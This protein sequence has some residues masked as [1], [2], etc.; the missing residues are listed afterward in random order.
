MYRQILASCEDVKQLCLVIPE[1]CAV[2]WV[3]IVSAYASTLEYLAIEVNC[4]AKILPIHLP[5]PK[6]RTLQ[7]RTESFPLLPIDFDH[8]FQVF[9]ATF[10]MLEF[11]TAY[12]ST[13]DWA[14]IFAS[15]KAYCPKLKEI[16]I[17]KNAPHLE[18]ALFLVSYGSQLRS[19]NFQPL[20]HHPELCAFVLKQSLKSTSIISESP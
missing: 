18:Y 2:S 10:E 16:T 14:E 1:G 12:I 11:H 9:G 17:D 7:L 13:W 4:E 15:I 5:F 19:A 20:I 6:L 8:I 3:D